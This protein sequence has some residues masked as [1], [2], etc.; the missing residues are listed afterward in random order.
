MICI[1]TVNII[2]R[3]LLVAHDGEH[4]VS[5]ELYNLE[6]LVKNPAANITKWPNV[7]ILIPS[8]KEYITELPE[9]GFQGSVLP[10]V[11]STPRKRSSARSTTKLIVQ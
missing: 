3:F 9:L 2:I 4:K 8:L 10:K 6:D 11:C 5:K 7:S 1:I